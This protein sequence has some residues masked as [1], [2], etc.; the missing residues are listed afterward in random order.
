MSGENVGE[1]RICAPVHYQIN[2]DFQQTTSVLCPLISF[3]SFFLSFPP[4]SK[5][6]WWNAGSARM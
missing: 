1:I 3:F 6:M 5:A 2:D 4:F